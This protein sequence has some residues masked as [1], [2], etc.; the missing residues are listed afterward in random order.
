ML[1][2]QKRLSDQAISTYPPKTKAR[3]DDLAASPED[4]IAQLPG[5]A[6][7]EV[8]ARAT[9]PTNRIVHLRD[10]HFVPGDLYALGLQ[11]AA[12]R[13]LSKEAIDRPH[14]GHLLE[15]RAAQIEQAAAPRCLA[16][17]HG[18]KRP[19]AEGLTPKTTGSFREVVAVLR[20]MERVELSGLRRQLAEVREALRG[21]GP[22]DARY[23]RA[24]GM[25]R[26]VVGMLEDHEQ[27]L[28]ELG[29][30]TRLLVAGE[31]EEAL[32]LDDDERLD[33]A[34]PGN[35]DGKVRVGPEK[36]KARLGRRGPGPRLSAE[37]G[38]R[39]TAG[40]PGGGPAR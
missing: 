17:H 24:K 4:L 16:R 28:L 7:V 20:G 3:F 2:E 32:P 5:V 1:A 15:V 13:P 14:Q 38:P 18:L 10:W 12:G 19:F 22:R 34:R 26:E 21:L 37:V 23:E 25:E 33:Q 39:F 27:R 6:R 8:L 36:L 35:P 9:N 11:T 29:A 30:S 31:V 40:H